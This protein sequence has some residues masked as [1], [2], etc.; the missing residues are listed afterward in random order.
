[1]ANNPVGV[2]PQ[3]SHG[4]LQRASA[5][6]YQIRAMFQC[7]LANHNRN[8][9]RSHTDWNTNVRSP[10]QILNCAPRIFVELLFEPLV[11]L[12]LRPPL[13]GRDRMHQSQGSS[14][15]LT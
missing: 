12:Q 15:V 11:H 7:C 8:R 5:D 10:F 2:G 9:T 1:M 14:Q 6:D 13:N 3:P 4:S